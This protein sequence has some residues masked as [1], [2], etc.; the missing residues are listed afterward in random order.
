MSFL[1]PWLLW[2]L[3]L[4]AL[5]I[6][7][8]LINQRRF[9]TIEWAAMMFLL[10]AHRMSRGY[11]R[12][13]QILIMMFRMLAVA[14]LLIAVARPLASGWLG[15]TGGGL[16]DVTI[17]LLD[18]SP[19]MQQHGSGT[20]DSKLDTAKSHLVQTL[21]TLGSRRWVYIESTTREPHEI[22]SP[23]AILSL[24]D[25]GPVSAPADLPAMLQS[26]YD[27]LRANP[28]GRSEIWICSDLRENDWTP[29]SGRW[30][31]LRDAFAASSQSVRFHLLAYPQIP[32]TNHTIRVSNVKRQS[33]RDGAELVV[34]IRIERHGGSDEKTS[35]P[36]EFDIEGARSVLTA[37]LIGPV[38]ELKDHRIPIDKSKARGW[39]RVSIPADAN[40]ADDDFYFVF[41]QPPPRRSIIVSD[42]PQIERPLR[43]TA[44]IPT[45]PTVESEATTIT[46][47]QLSLQEW[48]QI[49]LV[50]WQATLPSG[51]DANLLQTFIDRGGQVV[52]FPPRAPDSTETFGVRW[53]TWK[54]SNDNFAV[55]TFR[56]DEDLLARTSNGAALPVGQLEVRQY[57]G[58]SGEFTPL[59]TLFGNAPLLAR[60]P[61]K[62]GG[63]YFWTTT[64]A[65]QDS[66][67]ATGGVVLYAFVQRALSAGA[68]VLGKARQLNAGEPD[69]ETPKSWTEITDGDHGLS[70]EM[71]FHRGVFAANDRLLAVNR[72]VIEDE[73]RLVEEARIQGLF[74]GLDFARM[75]A[76]AGSADS[77]IQEI[78]RIFLMTMLIS[79]LAEAVLCMPKAP[80]PAGAAA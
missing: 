15:L 13:R 63:V 69:G 70:T 5:P 22:D 40:P 39:G 36:I 73:T 8:H 34:S 26:A 57:C 25:S 53:T 18:R 61:T 80:R 49:S 79:L 19:S 7:I 32:S 4:I 72:P 65:P 78:W 1:Q 76:E 54:S 29:E 38:T 64:P 51:A 41:D 56:S 37:E 58:L 24:P 50:I 2:A 27:Y 48:D 66:S 77:L 35:I 43:L 3:P 68:S 74:K 28:A 12:V 75:D 31:T 30:T 44:S 46:V 71:A 45:D 59:A 60:V 6:I 67:L 9:Q 52:F 23:D 11:S 14:T 16:A 42:D 62:A 17:V 20:G 55:E 10:A 21:K 47:D 33:T